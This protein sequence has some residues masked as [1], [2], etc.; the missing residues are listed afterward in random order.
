[1][2]SKKKS[3]SPKTKKKIT[4]T[5]LDIV[6]HL[7]DGRTPYQVIG[8]KIGVTT[9]T[10]RNRVNRMLKNGILQIIGLVDPNAI[11]GHSSAFIG[12]KT[13]LNKTESIAKKIGALRGV[14]VTARVSGRFDIITVGLFNESLTLEDF[15]SGELSKIEGIISIETFHVSD[16]QKYNVRYVL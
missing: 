6:R 2:K 8:E 4:R 13:E 12:I 10:V 7:W 3:K 11:P 15:I 16:G 9:N 5:D 14:V 1:M